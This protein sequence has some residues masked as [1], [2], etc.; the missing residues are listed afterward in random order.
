MRCCPQTALHFASW[1][2]PADF[3]LSAPAPPSA[4]PSVGVVPADAEQVDDPPPLDSPDCA[5]SSLIEPYLAASASAHALVD[6]LLDR[7]ADINAR[8]AL[9]RGWTPLFCAAHHGNIR[10]LR[11]LL[12]RGADARAT[13][14]GGHTALM[15][16]I[17][18]A[19]P[20]GVVCGVCTELLDAGTDVNA[21][22]MI[23][24]PALHEATLTVY[25][26][27]FA[28]VAALLRSRGGRT[29]TELQV[30]QGRE[31]F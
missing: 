17:N 11:A 21:R 15:H 2:L 7:K 18:L 14:G 29:K 8:T 9:V 13:D 19:V 31:G 23:G 5:R 6:A 22:N 20:V 24:K 1:S 12:R 16:A 3:G 30:Q 28:P 27:R 10:A 26:G 4:P 25:R